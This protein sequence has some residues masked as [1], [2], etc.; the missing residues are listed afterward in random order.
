MWVVKL[1]SNL[2]MGARAYTFSNCHKVLCY[3]VSETLE[4]KTVE[5]CLSIL[6][7]LLLPTRATE[8]AV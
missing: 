5:Y 6:S 3:A 8:T 4:D 1:G 7:S 2:S